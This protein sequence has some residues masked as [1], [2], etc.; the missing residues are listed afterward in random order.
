VPYFLI[1]VMKN[2]LHN[3]SESSSYLTGNCVFIEDAS[4]MSELLHAIHELLLYS[5]TSR[6]KLDQFSKRHASKKQTRTAYSA[7]NIVTSLPRVS[8]L[9]RQAVEHCSPR[10]LGASVGTVRYVRVGVQRHLVGTFVQ[11]N[12]RHARDE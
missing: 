7:Q 8:H 9:A 2:H 3:T 5:V 12:G 4:L 1:C 10:N 6:T 11:I